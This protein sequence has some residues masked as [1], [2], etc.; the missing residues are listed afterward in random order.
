MLIGYS[1]GAVAYSDF[2]RALNNLR[3][4]K[5]SAI[6]LSA[7]REA[8]LPDLLE[9]LPDLNLQHYRY[10]SFHAPSSIHPESER[11]V[12]HGLLKVAQKGW[13]IIVHPNII[14]D[15]GLWSEL[16]DSL[17][18]ENMDKRKPLGRTADE[19]EHY[20]QRL[21][22]SRLCFDIGHA[23]QVDPTM[24]VASEILKRFRSKL[25]QIHVSEVDTKSK[26]KSLTE[27][28][29]LAFL[30]VAPLLPSN[31]VAIIEATDIPPNQ[32]AA[33]AEFA[34]ASLSGAAYA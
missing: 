14:S 33:E 16:G 30:R 11:A 10:I 21:P 23:R 24:T 20:F 28:S 13:P 34:L 32:L 1:T 7:L 8:E 19:L 15:I 25:V 22:Q 31:T 26:H 4:F 6:E 2:R 18:I 3:E 5:F 9:A 29:R 12:V 17:L 27:A